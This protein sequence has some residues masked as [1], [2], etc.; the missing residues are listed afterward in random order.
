[1]GEFDDATSQMAIG[2]RIR[3]SSC[4]GLPPEPPGALFISSL[5]VFIGSAAIAFLK[6]DA[7]ANTIRMTAV[8]NLMFCFFIW[9]HLY[10]G[11]NHWVL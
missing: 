6:K 7:I 8:L 4:H 1:M 3:E 2:K 9:E 11:R 10:E 5:T